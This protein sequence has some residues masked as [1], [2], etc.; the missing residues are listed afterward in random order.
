MADASKALKLK[1]ANSRKRFKELQ[2]IKKQKNTCKSAEN[3][4]DAK[5]HTPADSLTSSTHS[6]INNELN[7]EPI[8]MQAAQLPN[9]FSSNKDS[10]TFFDSLASQSNSSSLFNPLVGRTSGNFEHM[11]TNIVKTPQL[12]QQGSFEDNY[13]LFNRS[14][15]QSYLKETQRIIRPN[16]DEEVVEDNNEEGE[17]YENNQPFVTEAQIIIRPNAECNVVEEPDSKANEPH[18]NNSG[19]SF[20]DQSTHLIDYLQSQTQQVSDVENKAMRHEIVEH[21]SK[22]KEGVQ[23]SNINSINYYSNQMA[24]YQPFDK[25]DSMSDLEKRNIDLRTKLENEKLLSEQQKLKINEL[26]STIFQLKSEVRSK[27][28]HSSDIDKLKEELQCHSQTI[29]LLVSEKS[30][31]SN[32]L[33]HIETDYK[34]KISECDELQARLKNS[35]SRAF[36]L[37]QELNHFKSEKVRKESSGAE[38]NEALA[39]LRRDHDRLRE[40]KDELYQDLLEVR[41]KLKTTLEEHSNLQKTNGELANKLS[42][43]EVKIQQLGH[44]GPQAAAAG[45]LEKLIEQKH[46]LERELANM[47][48]LLKSLTKERDESTNN[49]QHYTEKLNAQ[50]VTLQEQHDRLQQDNENL[51]VQEQNRIRHIGDLERQLQNIQNDRLA[52]PASV[53]DGNLKND[54][55]ITKELCLQLQMEKTELEENYTKSLNEK[56][57][58][59]KELSAKND[60]LSQLE[61]MIEQLRGNQPDSVKLLATMESDKVAAA[62]AVQQ[63]KELKEQLESMREVFVKLDNDKVELT[64]KLS[65][66]TS[67]GK[68]LLEKLQKTELQLQR[69]TDAIEIKDRELSMLRESLEELDKRALQH[70]QL[71][72]RL[73]HYEANDNASQALQ[74]EL[75]E[76]KQTVVR[77]TNDI[78]NLRNRENAGNGEDVDA[79]KVKLEELELRNEELRCKLEHDS[80]FNE[81]LEAGEQEKS[82]S[83]LEKE[84]AMERLEEKVKRT[85]QEI[86]DLTDEKQR[87]EHLVLQLQG[88]TETIGEYVALYQHQRMILKQKAIEKDEQ[89]RQLATDRE[90]IKAKLDKLNGLV[91]KLLKDKRVD[92]SVLDQYNTLKEGDAVENFEDTGQSLGSNSSGDAAEEILALLSEIKTSN[93]VEPKESLHSCPYCSG[94]LITV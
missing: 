17:L 72:D 81:A 94:Q 86:A 59:L 12:D 56:E 64:E 34:K 77:L 80:N 82:E 74:N 52:R 9:Y 31:L 84:V 91:E 66:E 75:Q 55:D 16:T 44:S 69:L 89:L 92:A 49:Y 71:A 3:E 39:I 29:R 43:A 18:E 65:L 61:S 24:Q 37:E 27:V 51:C 14:N 60:S 68:D 25:T 23:N 6:S 4:T 63:N 10:S 87:L 33:T 22:A 42:L 40:E 58:L 88:E 26:E 79:L 93:L 62:R 1:L 76:A 54:L 8:S 83:Y 2:E 70:E 19:N 35:R 67:A 57:M 20:S 45:D 46:E 38:R 13:S 85:M 41:E 36:E 15:Q 5:E 47:S 28:D 32:S 48:T 90:Q 7:T 11:V 73:R 50:L 30:E 78:N 53:S 21:S